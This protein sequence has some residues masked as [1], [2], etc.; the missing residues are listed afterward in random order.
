LEDQK[1]VDTFRR[2]RHD[3]GNHLQV[4]SGYL[5]LG[6]NDKVKDYIKE[7]VKEMAWE[8]K[9]FEELPAEAALYFYEQ[10]LLASDLGVIL[11][12]EDFDLQSLQLLQANQEP[13]HTLIELTGNI[14]KE[15]DAVIFLSVYEDD[16]GMELFF[17]SDCFKENPVRLRLNRE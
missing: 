11:V 12:Y 4:I 14:D 10:V 16:K 8:R 17:T 9:I 6:K 7:I 13:Y 5:E 1:V 3:F 2:I 15:C